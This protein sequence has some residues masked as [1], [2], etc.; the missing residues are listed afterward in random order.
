M[1]LPIR[2]RLSM[3]YFFIF[4]AAS[5][6]L[7]GASWYMAQRSLQFELDHEME[8]RIDDVRDFVAA[9]GLIG[10]EAKA[11]ATIAAEFGLK[12]EGKWL[13]IEDTHGR[14]IFR[15]RHMLAAP[16]GIPPAASLPAGGSYFDFWGMDEPVRSLRRAF[17]I[18]GHVWV[19]ETGVSLQKTDRVLAHFRDDLLLIA[20]MVLL[21][22]GLAGHLLSRR[23]LD[24]VAAIAREAQRI[25]EGNL[26]SRLPRLKTRD[27]LAHLSTTL[28]DMLER[29]ESGVRSVRDFTAHASHELRTPVA[30]IRSEAD[31]ALHFDRSPRECREAIAVIG[32]EARQMSSLLDSLLFLARVDAGTEAAQLE[33][34]DAQQVCA[35]ASRKWRAHFRTADIQFSVELPPAPL[36]VVAD[37]LY[38]PRLL[39]I[40]LENAG[41]YT[42]AGGMIR[43]SLTSDRGNR[44]RFE[45]ADNGVGIS[46]LDQAHIFD[47]FYRAAAARATRT[48][49]SGLGLALAAWIAARH[50]T[51]IEVAS[52]LGAGSSF[53]WTLPLISGTAGAVSAEE[54]GGHLSPEQSSSCVA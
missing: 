16:H 13:Q 31:L 14:W 39:N 54:L 45:I 4:A 48:T 29:I 18:D 35:G 38:L 28:N 42:P 15:S 17:T 37:N 12:D 19:V 8:E 10:D 9:Q 6:L 5:T 20:P 30:L 26:Q 47:R 33:N 21:M 27:E 11:R 32:A 24:P 41:K 49:G 44:A 2:I 1:N 25:H 34:V 40:I 46:P 52:A 23:A 53:S 51:K 7:A 50:Q 3:S 43:L 22:A 36:I